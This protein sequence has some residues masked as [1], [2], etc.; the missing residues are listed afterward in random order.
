MVPKS[1]EPTASDMMCKTVA[2][3]PC[4]G[5]GKMCQMSAW[6]EVWECWYCQREC[7]IGETEVGD[8]VA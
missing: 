2:W 7:I 5:C 4:A 8:D 1:T 6:V 3:R